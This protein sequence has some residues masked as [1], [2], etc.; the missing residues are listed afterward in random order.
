MK[1]K[2]TPETYL[3]VFDTLTAM[4]AFEL[5][6]YIIWCYKDEGVTFDEYLFEKPWKYPEIMV[7]AMNGELEGNVF[8]I[9][10]KSM[11]DAF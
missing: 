2:V 3:D 4:E 7:P 10:A 8:E 6:N 9:I 5:A 11:E 1:D